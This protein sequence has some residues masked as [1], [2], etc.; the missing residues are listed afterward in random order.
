MGFR[1]CASAKQWKDMN[2]KELIN[3]G[4]ITDPASA[5]GRLLLQAAKL[6]KEKG[7]ERTTV[8]DLA[9]AVGIQSGSIFHH[10]KTKEDILKAV[11]VETIIYNTHRMKRKLEEA[12]SPRE[13]VLALIICELESVIGV[14]GDAMAVLVYEWRSLKE[15]NQKSILKMRDEYEQL[16]LDA[17]NNAKA[18]GQIVADTFILRRFL[19]GA[20]GWTTNWY[21]PE[22]DIT[23]EELAEQALLL[24]I[25]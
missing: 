21:K 9:N 18:A 25:K 7:Y 2:S 15:E 3:E 13:E 11:M 17:L 16:W 20:L 1:Q 4:L 12:S 19:S 24:A 10:F 14:T 6:F 8:R 5:K 22:G 23:L